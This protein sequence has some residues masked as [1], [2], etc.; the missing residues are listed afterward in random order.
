MSA[1][2][3]L[4]NLRSIRIEFFADTEILGAGMNLPFLTHLFVRGDKI[5]SFELSNLPRLESLY[6]SNVRQVTE[7]PDLSKNHK[8]SYFTVYNSGINNIPDN[9]LKLI[10]IEESPIT[11]LEFHASKLTTLNVG[12]KLETVSSRLDVPNLKS[13]NLQFKDSPV[14]TANCPTEHTSEVIA[15]FCKKIVD[16]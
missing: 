11:N 1:L 10:Q 12:N 14:T 5:H 3:N 13:V 6:L 9:N 2:N 15:K 4:V 16:P 7:F 8:M